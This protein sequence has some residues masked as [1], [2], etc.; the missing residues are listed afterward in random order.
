[1]I[2]GFDLALHPQRGILDPVHVRH[3]GAAK[4]LDDTRHRFRKSVLS[5]MTPSLSALC[6]SAYSF[7]AAA[8]ISAARGLV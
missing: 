4:F 8:A 2:A 7:A 5:D 6:P 1:L 3:R